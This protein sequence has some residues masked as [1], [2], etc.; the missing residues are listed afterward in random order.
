M[1]QD[2]SNHAAWF[3]MMAR[4]NV[5][6]SD[7]DAAPGEHDWAQDRFP[8]EDDEA[9]VA[10]ADTDEELPQQS[11][12]D[13]FIDGMVHNFNI[14]MIVNVRQLG[15]LRVDKSDRKTLPIL[16]GDRRFVFVFRCRR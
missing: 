11:P 2:G 14:D 4:R 9:D 1:V 16:R 3:D 13:Q 12:E 5:W 7:D 6:D 8:W 10:E 15:I